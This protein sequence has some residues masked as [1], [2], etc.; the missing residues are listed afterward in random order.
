MKP[1]NKDKK[2]DK[3]QEK[4][5]CRG[6][7]KAELR[8]ITDENGLRHVVGHAAVFNVLSEDLGGFR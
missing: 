3:N 6:W 7:W 5:E 1:I 8:T 2:T 4:R